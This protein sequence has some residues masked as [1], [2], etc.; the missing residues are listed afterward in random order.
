MPK[1]LIG[2]GYDFDGSIPAIGPWPAVTCKYRPALPDRVQEYFDA[3]AA[4]GKKRCDAAVKLLADHVTSWD[5]E[6]EKG[7]AP[8]TEATLRKV[9]YPVRERLVDLVTGYAGQAA[10]DEKNSATG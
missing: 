9:P 2:D 4:G 1:L 3:A 10:A 6:T 5:V 8:V 7:P